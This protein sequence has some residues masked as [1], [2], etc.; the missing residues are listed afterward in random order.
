MDT[1]TAM[2]KDC[3]AAC[4]ARAL[5]MGSLAGCRGLVGPELV[6]SAEH[7]LRLQLHSKVLHYVRCRSMDTTKYLVS[8]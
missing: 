5:A 8:N 3:W 7:R 2:P 1:R 4:S 6:A